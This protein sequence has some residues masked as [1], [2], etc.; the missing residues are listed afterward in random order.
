MYKKAKQISFILL[1]LTLSLIFVNLFVPREKDL[2]SYQKMRD[3]QLKKREKSSI[4]N[5]KQRR[6]NVQKDIWKE[7]THFHIESKSSDLFLTSE[8]NK[9]D[10]KEHFSELSSWMENKGHEKRSF[11]ADFGSYSLLHQKLE[12]QRVDFHFEN[13]DEEKNLHFTSDSLLWNKE[14]DMLE[15]NGKARL[16]NQN[17]ELTSEKITYD[18]TH[19]TL[20]AEGASFLNL[21]DSKDSL[22]VFGTIEMDEQNITAK[23]LAGYIIWENE[24]MT[25]HAKKANAPYSKEGGHIKLDHV[26]VTDEVRMIV[27]NDQKPLCFGIAEKITYDPIKK[28]ATLLSEKSRVLFWQKDGSQMSAE[29]L[30]V[31]HNNEVKGIGDVHFS[32][33]EDESTLFNKTFSEYL[34]IK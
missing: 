14:N 29:K 6:E 27:K 9:I 21:I 30:L 2:L 32:F 25:L 10:L 20:T 13:E 11:T 23:A 5:F 19:E 28:E 4:N 7:E 22:Y 12:A 15:F 24:Q 8:G 26:D 17:F 1:I 3:E 31:N 16:N 18:K 34:K 33:S